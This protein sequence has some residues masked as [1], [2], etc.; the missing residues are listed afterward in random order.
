[1]LKAFSFIAAV[2]I[3]GF[4]WNT[5]MNTVVKEGKGIDASTIVANDTNFSRAILNYANFCGGCHGEKMDAFVDRKWKHGNTREDLFKAIKYGYENEGM[6]AYDTTFTDEDTYELSDYILTGIEKLKQYDFTKDPVQKN[7]FPSKDINIRLDTVV[8]GIG[9][10]WGMIFLPN[11]DLLFTEKSGKLSRVNKDKK[12]QQIK[13]LPEVH[14]AQQA[15]LMDIALH[16]QFKKNNTLYISYSAV[17]KEGGKTLS[18]TA[19]M[20]AVLKGN[21][22]T[23][24]KIIFEALPYLSA[25]IHYGCRLEFDRNGFLYFTVGDRSNYKEHPQFLTNPFGKVH[26]INDDGTVP[27]DNPF[28]NTPD[29][30]GSIYAYGNRNPQGLAMQPSTGIMWEDEHGPR[31]GDEVNI[32]RAGRN[33]GWPIISYGIDYTGIPITNITKKEGLEQPEIYWIPSIGPG[34]MTFVKGNRYPEWKGDLMATSMRY[35]YLNRC[36]IKNKK[37]IGQE[38]L[39]KNM[40][41]M[42]DIQQSPDGYLY[43]SVEKGYIFRLVPVKK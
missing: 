5:S 42:R 41:R 29:A 9:I 40:G 8:K 43:I 22:L 7:F 34:G 15:G 1:M 25:T 16:P 28:V 26:R 10:A 6:P 18:T 24:Q 33:Y 4:S 20:Q 21:E 37:I 35:G 23:E 17:K 31:G 39:I 12:V 19:I 3:I 36:I 27:A 14:F 13:G 30:V 2:V 11:G 32:V 38:M